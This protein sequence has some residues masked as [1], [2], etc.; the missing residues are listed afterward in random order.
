MK[1]CSLNGGVFVFNYD[2]KHLTFSLFCS[3][4]F[5]RWF[6]DNP[7]PDL[8]WFI[9]FSEHVNLMVILSINLFG[10]RNRWQQWHSFVLVFWKFFSIWRRIRDN[11]FVSC[12][13]IFWRY[14]SIFNIHLNWIPN[15]CMEVCYLLITS[16]HQN[17]YRFGISQFHI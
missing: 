13:R 8:K 5:Q 4:W 9:E 11:N 12:I 14:Y 16:K 6:H 15:N 17:L 1:K 7:S 3:K 2:R 10:I